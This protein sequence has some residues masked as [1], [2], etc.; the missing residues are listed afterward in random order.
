MTIP[1]YVSEQELFMDSISALLVFFGV[2][3]LL[4]SWGY[5]T[6]ISFKDDYAWGFMTIF[7]PP[8]SYIYSFFRLGKAWEPLALAFVGVTL[9][10]CGL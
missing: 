8:L 6:I 2:A 1:Y 5:L 9:V 7:L 3:S 10:I 4:L